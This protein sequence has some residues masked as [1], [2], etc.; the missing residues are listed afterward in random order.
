[1][2]LFLLLSSSVLQ[3]IW[4]IWISLRRSFFTFFMFRRFFREIHLLL[5]GINRFDGSFR[6]HGRAPSPPTPPSVWGPHGLMYAGGGGYRVRHQS[7]VFLN[8]PQVGR[9]GTEGIPKL[10]RILLL[11][12][13]AFDRRPETKAKQG[14]KRCQKGQTKA[15]KVQAKARKVQAKA[16][17]TERSLNLYGVFTECSMNIY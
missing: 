8:L 15:R 12:D 3:I 4:I 13:G 9:G 5:G 17:F 14:K 1:V 6:R 7:L 10:S 2:A 11:V 16:M